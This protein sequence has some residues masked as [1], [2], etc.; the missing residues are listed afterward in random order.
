[1]F[2]TQVMPVAVTIT[3]G[4]PR[5]E[6]GTRPEGPEPRDGEIQE[7]GIYEALTPRDLGNDYI[8]LY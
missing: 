5:V 2:M 7:D 8:Y 3:D 6:V 4:T 1:M